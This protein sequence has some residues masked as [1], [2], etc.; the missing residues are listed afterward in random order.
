MSG[1]ALERKLAHTSPLGSARKVCLT[2]KE[3]RVCEELDEVSSVSRL[4][5]VAL[6]VQGDVFERRR[7]AIDV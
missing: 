3:L 2:T 6:E 7:V 5:V 1:G 4:D